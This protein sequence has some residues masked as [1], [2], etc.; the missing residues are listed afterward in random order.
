MVKVSAPGKLMVLGEHAVVY[1]RPCIV[2]AVDQQLSVTADFSMTGKTEIIAPQV[3]DTRFVEA[4]IADFFAGPGQAFAEKFVSLNIQ[5]EFTSRVGFGS[6]SAVTVA[7][8]G[9]LYQLFG[10]SYELKEIFQLA[11]AVVQKVQWGG[12]GFDVAAAVYGGTLLFRNGG[13]EIVPLSASIPLIIGYTEIKADT[14]RLVRQVAAKRQQKMREI[15]TVFDTIQELVVAGRTAIEQ[16][17]WKQLGQ[18]MNKNQ[19]CLVQ[20]GVSTPELDA[21][22]R[23]ALSAGAWGAKLSG[24][25]GGDCM[26]AVAPPE[27][28]E[29]VE[30]AI[31]MAGGEVIEVGTAACGLSV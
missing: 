11:Y 24:A 9:A 15:E 16:A 4:A 21:L 26:I 22:I 17:D 8:I 3:S 6:S 14:M 13:E 19:D 2:T 31:V 12:S 10:V 5:S 20:L 25:G 30:A 27:L 1:G 28:Q 7:T 23:G 18:L 29:L